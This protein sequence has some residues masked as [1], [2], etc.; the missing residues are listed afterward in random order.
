MRT[1]SGV[2]GRMPIE[3]R[4]QRLRALLLNGVFV[5]RFCQMI[6]ELLF[7]RI[8]AF[9]GAGMQETEVPDFLKAFGQD[10]L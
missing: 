5:D 6:F 2:F 8:E 4:F 7:D 3:R 1:Y 9:F 10:M